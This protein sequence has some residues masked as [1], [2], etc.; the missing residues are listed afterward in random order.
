MSTGFKIYFVIITMLILTQIVMATENF[1][2]FHHEMRNYD[3]D[4]QERV[5]NQV[6]SKE[7]Q[8][9][10]FKNPELEIVLDSKKDP[11]IKSE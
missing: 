2:T 8:K 4:T 6:D 9:I 5:P 7:I 11:E 10:E 3:N 1:I